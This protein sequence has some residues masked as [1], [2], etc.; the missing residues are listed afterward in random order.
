MA[1]YVLLNPQITVN[2]VDLSDHVTAVS[3]S[4][5]VEEIDTTSFGSSHRT[6]VGGLS[7]GSIT[8]DLHQDFASGKTWATLKDLLGTTV[9]VKWRPTSAAISTTNPSYSVDVLVSQLPITNGAVGEIATISATWPFNG[10]VTV[11]TTP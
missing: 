2:G 10:A 11:K 6:R 5:T 9:N 7:D 8:L 1:V 4:Q 3:W